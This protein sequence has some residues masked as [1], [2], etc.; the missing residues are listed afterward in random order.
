MKRMRNIREKILGVLREKPGDT[1]SV[2]AIARAVESNNKATNAALGKLLKA[3]LVARPQKGVYSS[4][5]LS[6]K[7][8]APPPPAEPKKNVTAAKG[9]EPAPKLTKTTEV[10]ASSLSIFTIEL[11]VEGEQS[12]IVAEDFLGKLS[13][14][15]AVL[16]ARVKRITA[17]DPTKLKM[18]YTFADEG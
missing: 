14:N 9:A 13:E 1:F 17:A 16:D 2:S 8:T 12:K 6:P 15:R 3:G 11:L 10:P 18:R 5:D 7:T 4:K